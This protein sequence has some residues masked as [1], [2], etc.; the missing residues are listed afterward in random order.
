MHG[1]LRA[2]DLVCAPMQL[3][4]LLEQRPEH[5]VVDRHE[6]TTLLAPRIAARGGSQV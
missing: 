1:R 5:F 4:Y 6:E 3:L 2:S